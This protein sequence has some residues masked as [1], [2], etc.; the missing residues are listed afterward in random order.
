MRLPAGARVA[1]I[2][3]GPSGLVAAKHALEAGFDADGVRGAG[4]LG[5]QWDA[6]APHS[7]MW[8]G[9]HTNT[10]RAMTAFS[11]FPAPAVASAASG[12]GADPRLP[13]APTPR[14]FGVTAADPVRRARRARGAGRGLGGR[15]RA[16]RRRGR[17]LRP[18]PPPVRAPGLRALRRR[19]AARVRLPGRRAVP[20]PPRARLRQRDQRAGDRVRPRAGRATSS[21]RSASRATSSARWSTASRPTGSGTRRSARSSAA[22]CRAPSWAAGCATG[23]CASRAIRRVR[24][25]RAGPRHPRRRASRSARTTC[26]RSRDGQHRLPPG[27]RR[28]RARRTCAFADGD[29]RAG[30]RRRLRH[31]LRARHPVPRPAVWDVTGPALGLYRRT[32][33]PDLP[34][35]G[36]V[37]MFP[38]QG[39]FFPLLELQARWLVALWAGD[40]APPVDGGACGR[41]SR[42][43]APP[44]EVHNVFAAALAER[45][46]RRARPA[47]AARRSPSRCCSVRCSRPAT[48][49]TG[50]ARRPDAVEQF[51]DAARRVAARARRP[52]RRRGA[53]RLR[54]R[55]RRRPDPRRGRL[56]AAAGIARRAVG[57]WTA[58]SDQ[59][60]FHAP[61]DAYDRHIGRYGPELAE[62][63]IPPPACGPATGCSTSAAA[64]ARSRAS[65]SPPRARRSSSPRSTPRPRS[66]PPARSGCRAPTCGRAPRSTALRRRD[67]RRRAGPARRQLHGRPRRRRARDGARRTT[68]GVVVAAVWDY[69]GGMTLLRR[70]WEAAAALDPRAAALDEGRTMRYCTPAGS[71]SSSRRPGCG[72]SPSTRSW[73]PPGTTATTTCG[74][75]S[76]RAS[77]RRAPTSPRS[78]PRGA[79]RC[80]RSCSAGSRS[81]TRRSCS[82]RAR[83]SPRAARPGS[84]RGVGLFDFLRGKPD[85]DPILG[86]RDQQPTG[87]EVRRSRTRRPGR[88]A[89]RRRSARTP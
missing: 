40:A 54:P 44:L 87:L 8:P 55:R 66:P 22:A 10:S 29:A 1:V 5:G 78:A 82:M 46:R 39:P 72:T 48:G 65:S 70:F 15:R 58:V 79:T 13:R 9:M 59:H 28:G 43:P 18:V 30:R 64:P 19:A 3:A 71:G 61:A 67:L 31:G 33:H 63:L 89:R 84:V 17:R 38:A 20:R 35:F 73:S 83:S 2:G 23:C 37:G 25:A 57:G 50:R 88:R 26:A 49:S 12:G 36:A 80:G 52:R 60:G 77:A 14:D 74:R 76:S 16:V 85:V 4:D 81:S 53:A 21:P 32:F 6:G 68:G 86:N 69:A 41:R 34:G 7:G 75:R 27:G 62:E 47:R 42:T 24:G 11:D 56:S 45:A 51:G